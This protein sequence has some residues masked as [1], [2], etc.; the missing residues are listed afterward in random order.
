MPKYAPC[1]RAA[2]NRATTTSSNVGATADAS[3]PTVNAITSASSNPLRGNRAATTAI[4]GAPTTTPAAYAEMRM[5]ARAI[6]SS[7][8]LATRPG[9]RSRAIS[10]STP[11]ATNSV[12]PMP[13]P[14]RASARR[15]RRTRAG[16]RVVT[17]R[18]ARE[19]DAAAR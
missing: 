8:S 1:G 2:T 11:I 14:P 4:V 12:E 5:P 16:V 9:S 10:G 13:K 7:G 18:V 19:V 15:A 17:A 3:V 6:A